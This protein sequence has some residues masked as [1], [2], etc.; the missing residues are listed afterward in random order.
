[1]GFHIL[2]LL[3]LIKHIISRLGCIECYNIYYKYVN[4]DDKLKSI[5]LIDNGEEPNP[6]AIL[7]AASMF[8][9]SIDGL[10]ESGVLWDT[11]C[12]FVHII[13]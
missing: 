1:M 2:I 3:T 4:N 8:S 10:C 6:Y 12:I 5:V 13:C 11:I 9:T 7:T